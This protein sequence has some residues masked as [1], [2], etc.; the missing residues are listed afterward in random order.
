[1][2]MSVVAII[3]CAGKGE[4]FGGPKQYAL[5]GGRPLFIYAISAFED[6]VVDSVVIVVRKEEVEYT[7]DTLC[8]YKFSKIEGVFA[9]GKTRQDSVRI[10]FRRIRGI[11]EVVVVH[12]GAR[13]FVTKGL[14]QKVVEEA[15]E[16]GAAIPALPI[17]DTVKFS[18][19]GEFI[20]KTIQRNG[21]WVAQTP[22]AFRYDLLK[23]A[24]ERAEEEGFY[25]TDEAGLVER[26]SHRVRIVPG[27]RRNIKITKEEDLSFA[28]SILKASEC[29]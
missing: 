24:F 4:R 23:R 27:E 17:T 9:G 18:Q 14:I 11:P 15:R 2:I 26:L 19:D 12:D 1:M 7:I 5:L 3:P 22:Q 16:Y 21:F 20:Q 6:S 28:E 10:G 29:E 8:S 25:G 13:P